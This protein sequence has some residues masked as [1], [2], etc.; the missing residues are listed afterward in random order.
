MLLLGRRAIVLL[1]LST[2]IPLGGCAALHRTRPFDMS[3]SEHEKAAAE[4]NAR[5]RREV[6]EAENGGPRARQHRAEAKRDE[7]I[8]AAHA[9][10]A[11]AL[12]AAEKRACDGVP[13]RDIA[14]GVLR[15]NVIRMSLLE[16]PVKAHEVV[17]GAGVVVAT[18][19]RSFDSFAQLMRCRA[20]HAAVTRDP[21]DPLAVP[22]ASLRVYRDDGDAAVVQFRSM[23][24]DRAKEIFRRVARQLGDGIGAAGEHSSDEQELFGGGRSREDADHDPRTHGTEPS[25][26]EVPGGLIPIGGPTGPGRRP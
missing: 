24:P 16:R 21:S 1:M 15:L 18:D 14:P 20:A 19:G 12:L 11:R 25:G 6:V 3:A 10:A 2:G 26:T 23:E 4:A 7:E 22:G 5:A 9:E 13:S 17:E 8:A